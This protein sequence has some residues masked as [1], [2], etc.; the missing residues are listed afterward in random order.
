MVGI[1][2]A[3]GPS[4]GE[5]PVLKSVINQLHGRIFSHTRKLTIY[6][7]LKNGVSRKKATILFGY[8]RGGNAAIKIANALGRQGI[9]IQCL[10]IFDAHSINDKRKF[11]LKYDNIKRAYNFFQRNPRTAGKYGWWGINPYW[12]CTLFSP[13]IEVQQFDFTGEYYKKGIPASHLNIVRMG[14]NTLKQEET[15]L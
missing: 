7:Y 4:A 10:V 2:G 9:S 14:L 6:R 11:K 5:N 15:F 1:Y 3:G 13:F 8:S 12:G